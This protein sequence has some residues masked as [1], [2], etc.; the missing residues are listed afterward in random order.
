MITYILAEKNNPNRIRLELKLLTKGGAI[1]IEE[2]RREFKD[3][4]IAISNL[5][6]S[7]YCAYEIKNDKVYHP[8]ISFS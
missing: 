7:G 6:R 5:R 2:F 4:R 3:S 8:I 1:Q